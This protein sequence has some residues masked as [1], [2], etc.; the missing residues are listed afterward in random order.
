MMVAS[1]N[2]PVRAAK[3]AQFA[4]ELAAQLPA[5]PA[6]TR[7]APP[8]L[9][10]QAAQMRDPQRLVQAWLARHELPVVNA[11]RRRM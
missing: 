8:E 11:P 7:V 4:V 3:V 2:Q 9:V 5:S 6:G 1:S 10:W